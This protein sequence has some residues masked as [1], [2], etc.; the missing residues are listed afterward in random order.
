MVIQ[1]MFRGEVGQ[2]EDMVP[3]FQNKELSTSVRNIKNLSKTMCDLI[4][5][6]I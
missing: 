5:N 1:E 3:Q 6:M 2:L 4:K